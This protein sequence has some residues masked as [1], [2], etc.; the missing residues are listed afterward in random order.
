MQFGV[1]TTLTVPI[2]INLVC[3]VELLNYLTAHN[4]H[5]NVCAWVAAKYTTAISLCCTVLNDVKQ[6]IRLAQLVF[7]SILIR[8]PSTLSCADDVS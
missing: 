2:C 3:A 8:Q 7:L 6:L 4:S 1:V 5:R